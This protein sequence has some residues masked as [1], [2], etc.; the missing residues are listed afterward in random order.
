MT[1]AVAVLSYLFGAIPTGYLLFRWSE[2]KDIRKFGSQSIGATNVLRLKGWKYGAIVVLFDFFKGFLPVF[3][4]DRLFEDPLFTA[5]CGLLSVIGHCYPVFIRFRGGKGVATTVGVYAGIAVT[6]LL[7][8]LS[9]FL[10]VVLVTRYVSLSSLTAAAC[11][12]LAALLSG[13]NRYAIILGLVLFAL[14]AFQHR[15]NIQ[16]LIQGNEHKIGENRQ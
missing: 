6:P 13:E 15:S 3:I 9:L 11:Y 10:I 14:I 8:I 12:P 2:R 7:I 4:A 1:A 5:L 16:R